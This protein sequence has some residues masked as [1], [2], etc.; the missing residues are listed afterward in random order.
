MFLSPELCEDTDW[1]LFISVSPLPSPEP[2]TQQ[3]LEQKLVASQSQPFPSWW[4]WYLEEHKG[5]GC[6]AVSSL[7]PFLQRCPWVGICCLS[8]PS[9]VPLLP[10]RAFQL[11]VEASAAPTQSLWFGWDGTPSTTQ[12]MG[13]LPRLRPSEESPSPE[14]VTGAGMGT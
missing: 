2:H 13:L 3:L 8:C 14:T 11:S 5:K 4:A 7:N 10:G 9:S 6:W 12:G 1:F